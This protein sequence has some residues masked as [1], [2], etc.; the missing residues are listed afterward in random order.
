MNHET[1]Y[2]AIK[3]VPEKQLLWCELEELKSVT[4]RKKKTK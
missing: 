2:E 4:T 3:A 1:N